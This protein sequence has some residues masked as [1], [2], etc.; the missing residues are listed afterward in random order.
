VGPGFSPDDVAGTAVASLS[1][2]KP[3][4]GCFLGEKYSV[5]LIIGY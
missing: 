4:Q 5:Q 1:G 3:G 2:L